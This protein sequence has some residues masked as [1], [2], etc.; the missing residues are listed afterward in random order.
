MLS[1]IARITDV[2]VNLRA[3]VIGQTH[4]PS[5]NVS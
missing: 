2:F 4:P 3:N 5:P 1:Q